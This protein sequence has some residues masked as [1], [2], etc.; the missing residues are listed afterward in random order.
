MSMFACGAACGG[1][2]ED[3]IN[4]SGVCGLADGV[5]RLGVPLGGYA[6]LPL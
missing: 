1:D 5:S 6:D 2:V 3:A 4:L